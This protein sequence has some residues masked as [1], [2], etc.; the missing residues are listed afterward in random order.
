MVL[1]ACFGLDRALHSQDLALVFDELT[2][3]LRNC[4]P[5]SSMPG[6]PAPTTARV[7][8]ERQSRCAL[9]VDLVPE[10][11]LKKSVINR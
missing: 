11:T 9:R 6:F 7:L 5:I 3:E 8:M 10:G 1:L 2:E 4:R